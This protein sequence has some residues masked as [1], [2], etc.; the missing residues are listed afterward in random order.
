MPKN[1]PTSTPATQ[2]PV[3]APLDSAT[4]PH[5]ASPDAH[6]VDGRQ[7]IVLYY[8]GLEGFRHQVTRAATSIDGIHFEARP[9]ILGRTYL[10]GFRHQG[11]WYAMAMPGVF[12]RSDD[13][14]TEFEQGPHLFPRTM[15][16][17]ALLKRGE[18]LL[19]FWTLRLQI[20]D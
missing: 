2:M 6:V 13:G 20:A 16:H 4:R 3:P 7:E 17:A 1:E 8:H 19:V 14:L 10:R 11:R 12:Y 18:T 9:E 15:R 5:I